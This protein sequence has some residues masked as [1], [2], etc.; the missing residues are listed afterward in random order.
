MNNTAL[1]FSEVVLQWFA[2]SFE[3][4]A[5]EDPMALQHWGTGVTNLTTRAKE[6]A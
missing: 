4:C 2:L 5:A 1:H 3:L 6:Q